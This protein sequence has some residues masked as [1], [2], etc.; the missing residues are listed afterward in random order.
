M[1]RFNLKTFLSQLRAELST[2]K[3]EAGFLTTEKE[4]V[5][6]QISILNEDFRNKESESVSKII[7]LEKK[8]ESKTSEYQ[9]IISSISSQNE[10]ITKGF[11]VSGIWQLLSLSCEKRLSEWQQRRSKNHFS[12]ALCV[13]NK[14]ILA[15][16]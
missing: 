8:L 15:I 16:V 1:Y 13:K 14:T 2:A 5:L 12:I 10:S 3:A 4:R 7:D 6:K 11:Q 9:S